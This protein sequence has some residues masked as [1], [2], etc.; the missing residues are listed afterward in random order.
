VAA[1]RLRRSVYAFA[2]HKTHYD[3]VYIHVLQF[4]NICISTPDT[5][6]GNAI[7]YIRLLSIHVNIKICKHAVI[8]T[9]TSDQQ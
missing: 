1:T 8:T 3:A 2:I 6:K 7:L 9:L 5:A 4:L